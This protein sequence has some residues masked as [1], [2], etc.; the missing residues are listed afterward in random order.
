MRMSK[1]GRCAHSN[2]ERQWPLNPDESQSTKTLK[3]QRAKRTLGQKRHKSQAV[4]LGDERT[5]DPLKEKLPKYI[6]LF[7]FFPP[8]SFT[9][10]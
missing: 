4:N 10:L 8:P 5:A 6:P 3:P 9:N 1:A 2:L 7:E